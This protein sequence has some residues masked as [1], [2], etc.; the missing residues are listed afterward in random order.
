LNLSRT[1]SHELQRRY[2]VEYGLSLQGL[3]THH[4]VDPL[5]FNEKVDN[6]IP[7]ENVLARNPA[8]RELLQA[9]DTS[10]V[11]LWLLTNA[12][13]TH[14][15]RVVK[16][17]GVDDLFEGITYCDYSATELV[18]KPNPEMFRKAMKEAG[19]ES[20]QDCYFVGRFTIT[21]FQQKLTSLQTTRRSM[22][23]ARQT[24][25]GQLLIWSSHRRS[26]RRNQR[27]STRFEAS[28]SCVMSSQTSSR[29]RKS[30]A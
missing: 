9:I 11:K 14:G 29:P 20:L 10:R 24:S 15:L 21:K 23:K 27:P 6:A 30:A 28:R 16:I 3:V 26:L 7:L 5:D 13:I 8:L 25:A 22:Q 2:L 18:A 19:V 4:Q 17:L 12:Y 1:E